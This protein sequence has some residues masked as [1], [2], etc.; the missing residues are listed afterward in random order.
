MYFRTF[1]QRFPRGPTRATLQGISDGP[2]GAAQT[3]GFMRSYVL[4]AVRDPSQRIRELTLSIIPRNYVG[5]VRAIQQWTQQ[6]IRYV[7]DPIDSEGGAEL[8][9]EPVY[10]VQHQAGDCDDQSVL[11]ASMLSAIGHP[12]RFAAFAFNGGP[13]EHVVTQTQIG[14]QWITVETIE[15]R[16]LGWEPP[17]ITSR[18]YRKI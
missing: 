15:A 14:P 12:T 11:T 10:T 5:Q 18:Y 1:I 13:L 7:H 9:Q 16:P 2:A 17:N 8:V 3:M 4:A 6:N